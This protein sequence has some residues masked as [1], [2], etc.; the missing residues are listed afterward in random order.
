MWKLISKS[1][2]SLPNS[3]LILVLTLKVNYFLTALIKVLQ[4]APYISLNNMILWF[5]LIYL[6][7]NISFDFLLSYYRIGHLHHHYFSFALPINIVMSLF[8]FL[9]GNQV[10]LNNL[11]NPPFL[12]PLIEMVFAFPLYLVTLL[13]L[14]FLLPNI[15]YL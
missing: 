5:L 3:L 8:S 7:F 4:V 9:F 11:L 15:S 13:C 14:H 6:V 12:V 2:H 1:S 10:K